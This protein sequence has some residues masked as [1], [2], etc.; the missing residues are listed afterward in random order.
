MADRDTGSRR[1]ESAEDEAEAERP[2]D[3]M[4]RKFREALDRKRGQQ[5][6][7]NRTAEREGTA[8]RCRVRTAP[9]RASARSG[10]RAVAEAPAR[11]GP[12]WASD[13]QAEPGTPRPAGR[14]AA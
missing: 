10:A 4:K 6:E 12:R 1:A 7:H 5:A 3:E 9:R 11:R 2:E 14:P 13:G 8:A